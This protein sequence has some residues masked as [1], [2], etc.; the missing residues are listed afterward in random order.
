MQDL[1]YYIEQRT[2][3]LR[4]NPFV[5]WLSD[6]SVDPKER[7][8]AWLPCAAFFVF[9]FKDL[10]TDALQYPEDEA[11]RDPLKRAIN[12]HAAEDSVHW[13]WY[14]SDLRTLGLDKTMPLSDAL[15][16]LWG[17]NTEAQR[18][19]VYRLCSMADRAREPLLRYAMIAALES[20]AHLLFATVTRVSEE[21]EKKTGTRLQYLGATHFGR[22]PGH[23][24][25]QEDDTEHTLLQQV[26]DDRTR[27]KAIEIAGAVC[28]VIDL[29]WREFHR[30]AQSARLAEQ[31][32]EDL[33]A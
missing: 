12:Q 8:S 28:D 27:E 5:T 29:R 6:T 24:A 18:R 22:E 15:R 26:L 1:L 33:A 31:Q 20:Y 10:N 30:V 7:L 23:L 2:T 3:D 17:N 19:A 32:A 21:F 16:F 14:L 9:G 25:N 11:R 4:S 13:P